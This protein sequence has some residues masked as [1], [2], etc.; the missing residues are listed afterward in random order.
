[1]VGKRSAGFLPLVWFLMAAGLSAAQGPEPGVT[2]S[3]VRMGV[4]CSLSGPSSRA[5]RNLLEGLQAC[6]NYVN[7]IG[8]V[9]G[10]TVTLMVQDDGEGSEDAAGR[11]R[12]MVKGKLV[13]SLA[14]TSGVETTR[15]LLERGVLGDD[16]PAL[17]NVAISRSLFSPFRKNIF[18]L[19]MPYGDQVTL[20]IEYLLRKNP[21][22]NPRMALLWPGG[23]FGDEVE[24]V[25]RR[26]CTHYGLGIA[27]VERYGEDTYDFSS[28]L[29]RLR[30]GGADHV[31]VGATTWEVTRIMR[32]S[33]RMGW[34]PGF[35]GLS[36]T[37][38]P[39]ILSEAGEGADGYIAVDYLA[40][41]WER[42]PGVTLMIGNTE[43][44]YPKKETESLHRCYIVGYVS[45]LLLCEALERAGRDLT[46][47]GA[48]YA[49]RLGLRAV[50][51]SHRLEPAHA[52]AVAVRGTEAGPKVS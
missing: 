25:F 10:R 9:H 49:L 30:S 23:V 2:E 22:E 6:F 48:G 13:F 26:V 4:V 34:S 5:G 11:V 42:L 12:E 14:S 31:V 19:G 40:R 41:P 35:I 15:T 43:K 28:F 33:L 8:G 50:L 39:G 29:D 52:Q 51:A 27:G 47:Q 37:V 44:Y 21:A 16:V 18:F 38:D 36:S 24:E 32:G 3:E 7:E 17:V 45:G 20:A 46:I 1:M